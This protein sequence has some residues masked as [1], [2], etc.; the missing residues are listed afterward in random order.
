MLDMPI[1]AGSRQGRKHQENE[2]H[3]GVRELSERAILLVVADGIGSHAFGGSVAR[4]I[5]RHLMG[6]AI[7]EPIGVYLQHLHEAFRSEFVDLPEFLK[8]GASLSLA[9]LAGDQAD[10]YWA[11]DSPVFHTR[12]CEEPSSRMIAAPHV[13]ASGALTSCFKGTERF[14]PGHIHVELAKGDS[15]T[16]ASDGVAID[17]ASLAYELTQCAVAQ[18]FIDQILDS[19]V[20]STDSDDATIV[21]YV[22]S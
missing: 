11:G 17:E 13:N 6:D 8:C 22:H 9:S 10:I 20:A 1:Y 4:W 2:D 3:Y 12:I 15:L 16:I 7:D 18:A 14:A 19:S 5:V 21:C